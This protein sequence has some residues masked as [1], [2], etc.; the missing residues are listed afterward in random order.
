MAGRHSGLLFIVMGLILYQGK[1]GA[2]MRWII[3]VPFPSAVDQIIGIIHPVHLGGYERA[4]L[5]NAKAT[6][7]RGPE[8]Q[9]VLCRFQ[10]DALDQGQ[11]LGGQRSRLDVGAGST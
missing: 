2:S 3:A 4:H 5:T 10:L 11:F 7:D 9:P 8:N 1:D 6:T